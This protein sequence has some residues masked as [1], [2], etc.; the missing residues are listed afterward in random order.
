MEA[1]V[2]IPAAR[3]SVNSLVLVHRLE[4]PLSL[5]LAF[6]WSDSWNPSPKTPQHTHTQSQEEH[7]KSTP[8]C[9]G[10][11]W[12]PKP[13]PSCSEPTPLCPR[14]F[15]SFQKEYTHIKKWRKCTLKPSPLMNSRNPV[16]VFPSAHLCLQS[17]P[18]SFC[19]SVLV[20]STLIELSASAS[21]TA[22]SSVE[23]DPP[24]QFF[25][26]TQSANVMTC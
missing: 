25:R 18:A 8:G 14:F 10:L 26:A 3:V 7:A 1:L 16:A 5:N 15:L 22:R 23:A 19:P 4:L 20:I 12:E 17:A 11:R 6:L 13:Q 2:H 21:G 24:A 9:G